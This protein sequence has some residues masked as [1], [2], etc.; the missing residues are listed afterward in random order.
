MLGCFT[1]C[2]VFFQAP[3]EQ[4]NVRAVSKTSVGIKTSNKRFIPLHFVFAFSSF[5]KKLPNW[6][7]T[8]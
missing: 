5:S 8:V 2:Q 6:D 1:G 4:G 3:Q 7:C